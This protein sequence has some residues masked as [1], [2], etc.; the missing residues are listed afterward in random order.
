M[1]GGQ[2]KK[3]FWWNNAKQW[4]YIYQ[5]TDKNSTLMSHT[6][7]IWESM[8]IVQTKSPFLAINI[9]PIEKPKLSTAPFSGSLIGRD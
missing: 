8:M 7:S 5:H 3:G 6:L 4:V 9:S 1:E 2:E